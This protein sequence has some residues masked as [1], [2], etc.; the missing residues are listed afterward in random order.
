MKTLSFMILITIFL[1]TGTNLIG[2]TITTSTL[3][4]S[5]TDKISQFGKND[6]LKTEIIEYKVKEALN[7]VDN[8]IVDS[9]NLQFTEYTTIKKSIQLDIKRVNEIFPEAV[10]IGING[11]LSIDYNSLISILFK[12]ISEQQA[13]IDQLNLRISIIEKQFS[14]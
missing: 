6:L 4:G 8:A 7:I 14:K 13:I 9:T 5:V 11:E 10:S 12:A 3:D 2:Q 1:I